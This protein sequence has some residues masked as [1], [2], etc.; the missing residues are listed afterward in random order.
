MLTSWRSTTRRAFCLSAR[1]GH[2][3]WVWYCVVQG[4][5]VRITLLVLSG[6]TTQSYVTDAR[7]EIAGF[8]FNGFALVFLWSSCGTVMAT[9]DTG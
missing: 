5:G 3:S 4:V 1:R 9:K 8:L 7:Y 6:R 2:G